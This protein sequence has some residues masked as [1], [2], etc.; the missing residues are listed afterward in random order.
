MPLRVQLQKMTDP[1][2]HQS[3]DAVAFMP[4]SGCAICTQ[5]LQC[6]YLGDLLS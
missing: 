1:W 6:L 4:K 5:G 3:C 2:R